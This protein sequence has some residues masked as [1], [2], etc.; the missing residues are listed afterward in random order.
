MIMSDMY[1]KPREGVTLKSLIKAIHNPEERVKWDKDVE[2]GRI[3]ELMNN[4]KAL[5]FH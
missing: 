1:F 5:L 3:I 4:S 2:M